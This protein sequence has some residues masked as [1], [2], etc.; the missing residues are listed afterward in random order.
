MGKVGVSIQAEFVWLEVSFLM[1]FN[2]PLGRVS[3]FLRIDY[4]FPILK[5]KKS[6]LLEY[7]SFKISYNNE[8][9]I[10][11]IKKKI[12]IIKFQIIKQ[13]ET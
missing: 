2:F 10:L 3:E 9:I 5:K 13:F 12:I 4:F 1:F 11:H 7:L 8:N 6:Q